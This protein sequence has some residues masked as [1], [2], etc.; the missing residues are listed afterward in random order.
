MYKLLEKT[1]PSEEFYKILIDSKNGYRYGYYNGG[2][3]E[4][5][6]EK[7]RKQNGEEQKN[8]DTSSDYN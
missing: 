8:S 1:N 4:A 7:L 6:R 5:Y 3:Y 2:E